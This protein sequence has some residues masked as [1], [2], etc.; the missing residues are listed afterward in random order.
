MNKAK[1]LLDYLLSSP[2]S[3]KRDDVLI[4]LTD[5]KAVSYPSASNPHFSMH[6]NANVLIQDYTGSADA[7]LFIVLKWLQ[8]A[9]PD[10]REDALQFETDM[11]DHQRAD[12]TLKISLQEVIK[13][14]EDSAGIQLNHVD[15]P[16][17]EP[18]TIPGTLQELYANGELL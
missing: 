17:L 14:S 13:V 8:T 2:L 11:L 10:H 5:G 15:D 1:K 4:V 6:Y 7:L 3:L 12:I 9:Q 18:V 16:S